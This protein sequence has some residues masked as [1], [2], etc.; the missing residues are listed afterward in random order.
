MP[1][2]LYDSA[3]HR[4]IIIQFLT[5]KIYQRV[6]YVYVLALPHHARRPL[7]VMIFVFPW[8]QS[9]SLQDRSHMSY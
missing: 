9:L 6:M 4:V 3:S 1:S 7:S 8:P 2:L 5:D